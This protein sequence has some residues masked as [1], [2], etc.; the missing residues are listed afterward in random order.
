ME[1]LDL[2]RLLHQLSSGQRGGVRFLAQFSNPTSSVDVDENDNGSISEEELEERD[3]SLGELKTF[4]GVEGQLEDGV[5]PRG[6]HRVDGCQS[7]DSFPFG[8]REAKSELLE[9][10][11]TGDICEGAEKD[12]RPEEG[13][14]RQRHTLIRGQG[15]VS[16]QFSGVGD[17]VFGKRL[18]PSRFQFSPEQGSLA[19]S[20][21][22]L[23]FPSRLPGQLFSRRL[24]RNDS[25]TR[26]SLLS[27]S[28][29][30]LSF[31]LAQLAE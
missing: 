11:L 16:C 25:L 6:D 21:S 4:D 26:S 5:L 28:L 22:R 10:T 15:H 18:G 12:D 13:R 17:E 29:T 14:R 20:G 19:A 30:L 3:D 24:I 23:A 7:D 31:R 1:L 8:F 2:A 9:K 27:S